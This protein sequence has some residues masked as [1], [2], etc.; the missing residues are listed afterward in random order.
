[1]KSRTLGVRHTVTSRT[2][3]QQFEPFFVLFLKFFHTK[4][5]GRISKLGPISKVGEV[6][7]FSI[8]PFYCFPRVQDSRKCLCVVEVYYFYRILL[9]PT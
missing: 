3:N 5:V 9:H 7:C 8:L 6:Y 2:E 4:R 1:V